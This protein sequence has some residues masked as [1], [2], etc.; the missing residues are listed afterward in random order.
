MIDRAKVLRGSDGS[1]WIEFYSDG[2]RY[3]APLS[4]IREWLDYLHEL[5]KEEYLERFV[6]EIERQVQEQ[7]KE[8]LMREIERQVQ[9]QEK[10]EKEKGKMK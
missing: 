6:R 8:M 1:F 4:D 10:E 9:E 7:E 3:S 2:T 5:E